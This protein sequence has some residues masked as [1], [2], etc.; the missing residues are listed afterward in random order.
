MGL[1]GEGGLLS[2]NTNIDDTDSQTGGGASAVFS[3]SNPMLA[4]TGRP[5]KGAAAAADAT[6]SGAAAS[7]GPEVKDSVRQLMV[8]RRERIAQRVQA[9]QAQQ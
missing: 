1:A 3:A 9:M 4:T 7:A 5:G 8:E 2:A 6:S